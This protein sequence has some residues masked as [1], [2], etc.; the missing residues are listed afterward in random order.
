MKPRS[1]VQLMYERI[2]SGER[3]SADVYSQIVARCE[4]RLHNQTR[5]ST[6]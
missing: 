4:V 1:R 5:G 2:M 3:L 6:T